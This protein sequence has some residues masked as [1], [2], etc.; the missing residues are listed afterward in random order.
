MWVHLGFMASL[1]SGIFLLVALLVL[2]FRAGGGLSGFAGFAMALTSLVFVFGLDYAEVLIFPTL[3]V[4][5]PAVVTGI[6]FLV[7]FVL[8][9]W[10]LHRVNAVPRSATVLTIIGTIIFG[11]G[12]SGALPMVVVRVGSVLFGG[13]LV[14]LGAALWRHP[15]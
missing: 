8:F 13:A 14:S 4:E 11:L 3:A 6:L 5:F 1:L 15:A 12:L 9:A 7:G 10:A 2:Y